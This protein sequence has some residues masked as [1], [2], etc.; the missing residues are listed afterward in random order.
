MKERSRPRR[1]QWMLTVLITVTVIATGALLSRFSLVHD[2][3]PGRILSLSTPTRDLLRTIEEP[4]R[5]RYLVDGLLQNTSPRSEQIYQLLRQYERV[6]PRYIRVERIID[7]GLS[8]EELERMGLLVDTVNVGTEEDPQLEEIF[9]GV[10]VRYLDR[11]VVV[12]AIVD[13]GSVEFNI[14]GAI[15]SLVQEEP[16]HVMVV[17][18]GR[19]ERLEDEYGALLDELDQLYRVQA[20]NAADLSSS[21]PDVI[22]LLG[23]S[24]LDPALAT[25]IETSISRGVSAFLTVDGIDVRVS[26]LT[27]DAVNNATMEPLLQAL[28]VAVENVLLLDRESHLFPAELTSGEPMVYPPWI[29]TG[30]RNIDPDH[31]LGVRAVPVDFFWPSPI[32]VF[33]PESGTNGPL[34]VSSP[35]AWLQAAPFS[36]NPED[37][38]ALARDRDASTGVYA[39][40]AWTEGVLHEDSRAVVVGDSDFLSNLVYY[41]DS[42]PNFDFV[43]RAVYWLSG[44]NGLATLS[45]ENVAVSRMDRIE[46]PFYR[47]LTGRIVEML[48]VLI[49][50]VLMCTGVLLS[51]LR[52]RAR[53]ALPRKGQVGDE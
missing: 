52:R 13:A 25:A 31:P 47:H 48:N 34:I 11:R 5:V 53:M 39:V 30:Q 26:E 15:H 7:P 50:P 41:T 6:L 46:D 49:L 9:S 29:R 35:D 51:V 33:E 44:N 8:R 10:E 43:K 32:R 38:V 27:G 28:G 37:P 3:S 21:S 24:D 1:T 4:V 23:S 17:S 12:P 19:P 42:F 16:L 14:T 45:P 40:S 18:G 2:L 36:L 22:L 20:G